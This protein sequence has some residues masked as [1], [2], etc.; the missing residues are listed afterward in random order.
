ME[1]FLEFGTWIALLTLVFL[2]VILGID[3]IIFISIVTDRLPEEKQ[4]KARYI[5]LALA[6]IMRLI[7]LA[8]ISYIIG[9][10]EPI[11]TIDLSIFGKSIFH[12]VSLRDLILLAGGLFLVAKSTSEIFKIM[13]GAHDDGKTKKPSSMVNVI[14]Q[15]ILLDIVFSFDS[16]LT[17]IG[18]VDEIL[19]MMIAV[20]IAMIIMVVFLKSI[21]GFISKNPSIQILALAFL[22][23]IGVTLTME[24]FHN[25]IPKGYIYFSVIFSLIV[26]LINKRARK[27]SKQE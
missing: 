20:V 25:E 9:F 2:E 26:E 8:C 18:L 24:A 6:L 23:L 15:I 1:I 7:L 5:G 16:I 27:K 14:I 22:I 13:E 12:E 4:D 11:L 17:A 3:N 10:T 19:I 21:S